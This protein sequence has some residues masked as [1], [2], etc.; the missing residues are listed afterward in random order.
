M[1]IISV[2]VRQVAKNLS[3]MESRAV[4]ALFTSGG[5]ILMR[6]DKHYIDTRF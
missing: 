4:R 6:V 3:K 5:P 2:P 1:S